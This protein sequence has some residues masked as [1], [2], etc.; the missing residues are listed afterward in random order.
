MTLLHPALQADSTRAS[1]KSYTF[2]SHR[3]QTTNATASF[4]KT[5]HFS[6]FL[7]SPQK[8][9]YDHNQQEAIIRKL[10]HVL[11]GMVD[12]WSFIGCW[13][14]VVI[15]QKMVTNNYGLGQKEMKLGAQ[16]QGFLSFCFSILSLLDKGKEVEKRK[17]EHRNTI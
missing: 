4:L 17:G 1:I 15:Q 11:R 8:E 14:F 6:N 12:F 10:C 5:N 13:M 9:F 7:Q 2:P 3:D 16:T